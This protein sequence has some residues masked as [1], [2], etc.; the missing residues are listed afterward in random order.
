M[1]DSS[2]RIEIAIR[3]ALIAKSVLE[4]VNLDPRLASLQLA[5]VMKQVRAL[6]EKVRR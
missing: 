2:L 4:L 5:D 3:A 1:D 6:E